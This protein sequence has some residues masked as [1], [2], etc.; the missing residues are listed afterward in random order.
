MKPLISIILCTYNGP[1]LVKNCLNSI[2]AQDLKNFEVICMD[3]MSSDNTQEIIKE[4]MKKDKRIKLFINKKRLPEGKGFGKWQGFKKAKGKIIG[5][6]DQDNILQRDDL[7]SEVKKLFEKNKN[8]AGILGGLRHDLV[9]ETIV[10]YVSLV[11]T[12]SFF[13]YRS[14]DFLRNIRDTPKWVDGTLKLHRDDFYLTGGNCFFYLKKELDEVGGYTQDV[15]GLRKMVEKGV[16][17]LFIIPNAT[18]HYAE[19]NLFTLIKKKFKWGKTYH[20]SGDRFSYLPRTKREFK[21]FLKNFFFCVLIV[22]NF[23]Y[24]IK[25]YK[26]SGDRASFLFPIIA[27]LNTIA[28]GLGIL[29]TKLS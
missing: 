23:I 14:I 8:L 26:K 10:R 29:K 2:L 5:I 17:K 22:P 15:I 3:G 6:I 20:E 18:K 19:K 1:E 25:L 27:F 7:F 9:D 13:A 11:G 24:S 4:Y 21:S 12:D 16:D 28:Y